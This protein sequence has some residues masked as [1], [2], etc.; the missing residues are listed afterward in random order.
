[1][2]NI[3]EVLKFSKDAFYQENILVLVV[4]GGLKV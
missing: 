2:L 3:Y 4:T 1:M